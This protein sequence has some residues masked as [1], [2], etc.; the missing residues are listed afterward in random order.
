MD[1]L[2]GVRCWALAPTTVA[3]EKKREQDG[4][5]N[6]ISGIVSVAISGC[7]DIETDD[8]RDK[9]AYSFMFSCA[10]TEGVVADVDPSAEGTVD[11]GNGEQHEGD[12]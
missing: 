9:V 8:G 5:G 11:V 7:D 12:E 4:A 6:L 1:H 3:V 2:L 10:R